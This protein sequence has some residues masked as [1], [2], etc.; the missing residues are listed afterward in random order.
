MNIL[1]KKALVIII[2]YNI[3]VHLMTLNVLKMRILYKIYNPPESALI[4]ILKGLCSPL[5]KK[6]HFLYKLI[7]FHY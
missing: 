6:E 7:L 2:I 4:N 1:S 5:N 3:C